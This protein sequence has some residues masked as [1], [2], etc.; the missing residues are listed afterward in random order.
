MTES[1]RGG[2]PDLVMLAKAATTA[3]DLRAM[4]P[5]FREAEKSKEDE[6]VAKSQFSS[7]TH[8]LMNRK[9][10]RLAEAASHAGPGTR[11]YSGMKYTITAPTKNS[12]FVDRRKQMFSATEEEINYWTK[13]ELVAAFV[14]MRSMTRKTSLDGKE[15]Q[16][17]QE[18]NLELKEEVL[19]QKADI[20]Q[21]VV[22]MD[23]Q[24]TEITDLKTQ[25]KVFNGLCRK[26]TL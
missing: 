26:H 17:L 10:K 2:R 21:A 13:Q 7:Q 11:K 15:E 16:T 5:M 6:V 24:K 18:E 19:A 1:Y 9:S 8:D 22:V 25:I 4:D 3:E 23:Y 20:D 14:H 12:N